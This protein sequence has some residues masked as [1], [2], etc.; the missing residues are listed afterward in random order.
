MFPTFF[1]EKNFHILTINKI[2]SIISSD[3]N[4]LR[5]QEEYKNGKKSKREKQYR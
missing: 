3:Y 2:N 5:I 1:A 4:V